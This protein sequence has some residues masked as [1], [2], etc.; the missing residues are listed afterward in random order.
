MTD[1]PFKAVAVDMD[2]TFM[3]DDLTYDHERFSKVLTRL[4][5][6][7]IHFIVSSGRPLARLKRDF[8]G[9][10][11][12]IDIVAENGAL[13][14]KDNE[15]ISSHYLTYQTGIQLINFIQ[16]N[17][18]QAHI[19]ASGREGAYY[20]NSYPTDFKRLMNFYY[21]NNEGVDSFDEI[22]T[23]ERIIKLTLNIDSSLAEEM[24]NTFNSKHTE[25]IH[26]TTSGFDDI[27]VIAYGV[28]KAQG[29]KYFLRFFNLEPSQLIA[30]G[31]GLN[32]KEMLE[33]AGY[34]YAMA[35][36]NPEIIKLAKYT[37]PSN[38][39]SGVL[40]VLEEYLDKAEK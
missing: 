39:D 10:L 28:N 23:R 18:P 36:G 14:V 12:K 31:D 11:D 34:S 9:F 24:E 19:C 33:L 8:A 30:F 40:Q 13:L 32:D 35:N 16:E 2:G 5:K 4:K 37:A 25:R 29:L 26:C 27:D 17:Y 38:N 7:H 3:N 22:P 15:I 6:H 20:L 21:P 1:I